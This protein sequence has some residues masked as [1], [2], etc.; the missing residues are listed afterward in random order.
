MQYNEIVSS[1]RTVARDVLRLKTINTL[2]DRLLD[3]NNGLTACQKRHDE[4]VLALNKQIAI[5][6]YQTGLVVDADPEAEDKR[7]KFAKV[8]ES[9]TKSMEQ[10]TAN[11]IECD[12]D[13]QKA[14]ADVKESI[15][16]VESGEIKMD[17]NELSQLADNFIHEVTNEAVRS[18]LAEAIAVEPVQN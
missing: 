11:Y 18:K 2:R 4:S 12:A 13:F 6:N 7:L 5:A 10:V 8:V 9:A 16:K 3:L 1:V 14:I 17:K 15:A